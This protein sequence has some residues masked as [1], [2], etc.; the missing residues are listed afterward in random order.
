MENDCFLNGIYES[1]KLRNGTLPV[2][3]MLIN[4]TDVKI[5]LL[6]FRLLNNIMMQQEKNIMYLY[7]Q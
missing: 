6:F 1:W 2:G 3:F 5:F 4:E 7:L